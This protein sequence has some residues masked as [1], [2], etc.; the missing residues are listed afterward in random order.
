ME[1][2]TAMKK[3]QIAFARKY[4]KPLPKKKVKEMFR[5]R[6]KKHTMQEIAEKTNISL[7]TAKRYLKGTCIKE[8]PVIQ[9]GLSIEKTR[10]IAHCLF[11][12][13][14]MPKR[15][16]ISY[17]NKS[18][19]LIRQ[20]T[21][22]FKKVYGLSKPYIY[23]DKWNCITATFRSKLII[24]DL[25]SYTPAYTTSDPKA[26]TTVPREILKGSKQ[27][28]IAFL[29]A[30]WDDE[31]S[32]LLNKGSRSLVAVCYNDEVLLDIYK[33]H[34]DL[35]VDCIL[36]THRHEIAIHKEEYIRKFKKIIGFSDETIV[37]K[38]NWVGSRKMD[39]LDKLLRT[40]IKSKFSD[41]LWVSPFE[42]SKHRLR[43]TKVEAKLSPPAPDSL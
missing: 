32:V 23:V 13:N 4:A 36:R 27:N 38:G 19:G 30:F 42:S 34:R 12:G 41:A 20:F 15:Y 29:R 25:L 33:M 1:K 35:G 18:K 28:K 14:V 9:K 7:N 43:C 16:R 21:G 5:L 26:S 10:I 2:M 3:N 11:D 8:R 39:I 40:F 22:D 31:G 17:G 24:E 37:V 6:N